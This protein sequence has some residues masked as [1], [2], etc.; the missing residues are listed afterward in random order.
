MT[1]LTDRI[2][3]L[4]PQQRVRLRERVRQR[5]LDSAAVLLRLGRESGPVPASYEQ[6]R[7]VFLSRLDPEGVHYHSPFACRLTGDLQVAALRR[8]LGEVVRRH[9]VLRTVFDLSGSEPTQVVLDP[10]PVPVPVVD[11]SG[12]PG[13]RAAAEADRLAHASAAAA[14]DLTRGPLLRCLLL[15][16]ARDQWV[17]VVT[18]HHVAIDG[19]SMPIFV[20]ELFT[21]YRADTAGL[22]SPLPDLPVQYADY[23]TWQREW[24]AGDQARRQ[25]AFW[26]RTLAGAPPATTVPPARP[27]PPRQSHRGATTRVVLPAALRD[28]VLELGRREGTT[29]FMTLL[30]AF[31]VVL[32][33]YSG[34]E[35]VVVGSPVA[36]RVSED[37]QGLLGFFVNTL[38]LR[39]RP[40][41]AMPFRQLLGQ[42]REACLAAY[43]NADVPFDFLVRRLFPERDLDR[44]PLSQVNLTLHNTPP[45]TPEPAGLRVEPLELRNTVARFDLDLNVWETGDG[46]D[47]RLAYASDL[48]SA[49]EAARIAA[50]FARVLPAV[51][52]DPDLPIAEIPLL[53][54]GSDPMPPGWNATERGFPDRCLHELVGEQA[55]RTPDA[56]AVSDPAGPLSYR[57]LDRR[58][59]RLAR[60]LAGSGAGNGS[61]VAILMERSAEAVVALLAV[62]RSGAAYLPLDPDH[63]SGRLSGMLADSGAGLL[64]TTE[65]LRHKVDPGAGRVL[66]LSPGTLP[67]GADRDPGPS[68]S[69]QVAYLMYTSGSTGG[70]KGVLLSHRNL[71]NYLTWAAG[72]YE[73]GEGGG[74]P[75]HSS[76]SVDLTV[77]SVFAPLLAGQRVLVAAPGVPGEAL[78]ESAGGGDGAGPAEELS[79]VKLT[80]SHLEALRAAGTRSAPWT[81]RLVVGGEALHAEA[82]APWR[83]GRTRIVNEY[84][85]TET[86]VACSAYEV[87]DGDPGTGPVPIGRPI[88]NTELYV[89]DAAGQP[90][91][92]GVPGEL[93]VGGTGVSYGY[94]RRPGAT[95]ER[96]VPDP[97]SGRPGARLY[98]TG[99]SVRLL[100][101]GELEYLGRRDAQVK[102]RGH[103]VELGE[104]EVAIAAQPAVRQAAVLVREEPGRGR[105]LAAAV[106]LDTDAGRAAGWEDEQIEQWQAVYAD[107][108]GELSG[109]DTDL[110]GWTDSYTGAEIPAPEMAAWL[111]GTAERIRRLHPRRV[112]EIGC[113]TGMVLARI[114]PACELYVATDFSA[115]A[116]EHVRATK[117]AGDRDLAD[118]VELRLAPAHKSLWRGD[119][120]DTVVLNSVAQYFPSVDY[121]VRLISRAVG[122]IP[123]TGH[124][125]LGDLRS[126]PLLELFH[127][128]VELHRAARRAAAG[129]RPTAGEVR[130]LVRRAV[131]REEELCLDP[132]LFPRLRRRFPR[133][134]SVTV[135][136]KPGTYRNELGDYRYDVT[137]GIGGRSPE[138]DGPPDQDGRGLAAGDLR[139]ALAAGPGALVLRR[140]GNARL[141]AAL[142]ARAALRSA[143][144]RTPVEDVVSASAAGTALDS[145]EVAAIARDAGYVTEPSWLA[146]HPD[147]A[148]DVLLHRPDVA[149]APAGGLEPAG[150]STVDTDLRPYANDPLWGRACA[151]L[152][153]GIEA[154]LRDR[155]PAHMVP[156]HLV[157]VSGLPRTPGGKLDRT[158]LA[159]L[160]DA[161]L[162]PSEAEPG[163]PAGRPLTPTE[164]RVAAIWR[165]LLRREHVRPEHDFFALG[166]HSL[167]VFTLVFRLRE[168]FG[169]DVPVRAP[170]EHRDLA[171][172]AACVD[173][174]TG[175]GRGGGEQPARPALSR[176]DPYGPVPL[177][178][179]QQRLWFHDQLAPGGTDY[180]VPVYGRIAG[181]L[182]LPALRRALAEVVRRHHVLRTVFDATAGVPAQRV[183]PYAGVPVPVLDLGGLAPDRRPAA[184]RSLAAAE[185]DR[186]FDLPRG[187]HLRARLLRLAGDEHVLL[188]TIHHVAFDG[189]SMGV[190]LRELATLYEAYAAGTKSPLAELPVQYGDYARWQRRLV[191]DGH[192]GEQL[193]AWVHRLAGVPELPP[194]PTDRPRPVRAAA[195]GRRLPVDVPPETVRA[196]RA[197]ARDEDATVFMVLLTALYG[198]LHRWSGRRDL[199]V[200]TDVANRSE[201]A[202]ERLIGFFVNQLVLRADLS[203]DPTWRELLHRVRRVSL[204]AY[205]GQDVPYDEVV[206]ALNPRR[207]RDR[208]PLF[209]VKLVLDA[210]AAGTVRTA[211]IELSPYPVEVRTARFDLS[212]VLE[213]GGG[214]VTGFW[215][216]DAD[217]YDAATVSRLARDFVRCLDQLTREPDSRPGRVDTGGDR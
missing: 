81:R 146:G 54:P 207:G 76:L 193:D 115:A 106:V 147:G 153:P 186:P 105:R 129:E 14:F 90:V 20:R 46:L 66:V 18:F 75:V 7:L 182:D 26:E 189:W 51:A 72:A 130:A 176:S 128:S 42:T 210:P 52:A 162:G 53:P 98:R 62:L 67:A 101:S 17:V 119:A 59:G 155:L 108:Y 138:P 191:E 40:A 93:H 28:E 91:P 82:L 2:G 120:V 144:D 8:A 124:V 216:Y 19:W 127:T 179:A 166:G 178:S 170:F 73:L 56:V 35:D 117:L 24:V 131:E 36:H 71:V 196:V 187:P 168:A 32:A 174:L 194:L 100:P 154:R 163:G 43:E 217:L 102:L 171:G 143:D 11:V 37:V 140:V 214:P 68:T 111:D 58:A 126:L 60:R 134:T 13:D 33:R 49:G 94:W 151:A 86:A 79:L 96:F 57:E 190:L 87:R 212:L 44:N 109:P 50:S 198:T 1:D 77:T 29:L 197:L 192:L 137:L 211:G 15:R 118:R 34:Q 64:L 80:P 199:V 92:S 142:A 107:R 188:L 114:A 103:R 65:A 61:I 89:L 157:T 185:Y 133:I 88:Q 145:G 74:V 158:A 180:S 213:Q 70:P 184:A 6:Q 99:D 156:N 160:V 45:V 206:R 5:G 27:R 104:V 139:A 177:S 38:P 112:L 203:G 63:P 41:G 152:L 3:S 95:A 201:P 205:A 161:D 48:Y 55:A 22:P 208:S 164:E 10:A 9:E 175:A 39:A 21:L 202:T 172:L 149:T 113:G 132:R 169:V 204:D 23:A 181:D 97:F 110:S 12:L 78:A 135:S 30:A 150:P 84:G 209:T 69:D 141:A 122:A 123:G 159:G 16:P 25:L 173:A 121:L 200:G 165:E 136:P 4:P 148:V 125:F 167:L 215:E 183:L 83:D 31:Q 116:L 195:G 47:C 85:P